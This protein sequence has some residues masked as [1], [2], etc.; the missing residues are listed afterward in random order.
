L[1]ECTKVLCSLR[2][3][4]SDCT[5]AVVDKPSCANS[6]WKL[7]DASHTS[8]SQVGVNDYL[9]CCDAGFIGIDGGPACFAAAD[10]TMSLFATQLAAT[11]SV[12][13][14]MKRG[15]FRLTRFVDY[16][17]GGCEDAGCGYYYPCCCWSYDGHDETFTWECQHGIYIINLGD[18]WTW[19]IGWASLINGSGKLEKTLSK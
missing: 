4:D 8:A 16:S 12:S 2:T 17:R 14:I 6:S 3:T 11:V 15:K 13:G 18:D 10:S 9:F 7:F 19:A 1:F 5:T